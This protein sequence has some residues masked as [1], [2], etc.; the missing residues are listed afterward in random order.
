MED[1]RQRDKEK[2]VSPIYP[3]DHMHRAAREA[4]E[5]PHKLLPLHEA[6]TG[7]NNQSMRVNKPFSYQEIQRIKE[8]LGDY[9]EDP[10]KYIR[11][12]K[13]VTLLCDFTSK[14][15]IYILGQTLTPDSK[16]RV[17]GTVVAYGDVWLCN[18]SVG[19]KEDEIA[20]LP[21]GNQAVPA[22]EPDWDYN[23]SKGRWDQ[24]HFVRCVLEGLRQAHA[25]TLNYAKLANIEQEEKE[26][27]GKFL[28]SLREALHRFTEIDP[29]SEEGRVILKDFLLSQLQISALSY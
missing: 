13:S 9:L 6:P 17:L 15:V 5:Q 4:E 3:W 16:S 25:K 26:A 8:D 14:H 10:E 21:T 2:Q 27:P 18:E 11:A 29:E 28:A 1:R 20:D 23:T 19:K 24:S 12:L 7:R 22:I